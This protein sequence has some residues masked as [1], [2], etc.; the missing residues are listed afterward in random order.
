MSAASNVLTQTIPARI[1]RD[2]R[3][4]R[5]T[6]RVQ[7]AGREAVRRVVG[8]GDRLVLVVELGHGQDRPEDLLARDAHRVGDAV[9]DRRRDVGAARSP[10][11]HARRR[12]TTVAPSA[13]PELD[14]AEDLG[15][16][17]VVHDRPEPRR[18]IERLARRAASGRAPRRARR[19]PR[20]PSDGR[21]AA[22][23]RCRSG[24]CC[25]RSPS[26]SPRPPPRGRRR[27]RGRPAGS[28]RR[29]R[30]RSALTSESADRAEERLADLGRAGERDLVHA[31]VA[32]QRV[33]DDRARARSRR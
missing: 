32:G 18:G 12:R 10:R 1:R 29:A 9:E 30:A 13:R 22:T 11:G 19:A 20:G 7:S 27:R 5:L 25:R 8:D 24:R 2:S 4:A 15:E 21:R 31:R 33:A 23:P 3:C 26:R 14:V 17:P 16:L 28:C 6:S